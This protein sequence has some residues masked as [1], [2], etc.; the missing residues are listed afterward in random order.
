MQHSTADFKDASNGLFALTGSGAAGMVRVPG[1]ESSLIQKL[2]D[3]GADG[4]MCP[5]INTAEDAA[6]FVDAC[7]YPPMGMRSIG[8]FRPAEGREAYFET[9]NETIVTLAQIETAEAMGNLEGIAN[10]PGLDVLY[11]GPSDMSISYGGPPY[12]N[13]HDPATAERLMRIV[14]AAHAADKRAGMLAFSDEDIAL[15][16]Q[17]GIDYISVGAEGIIIKAGAQAALNRGLAATSQSILD[18]S[19]SGA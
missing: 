2:L 1:N 12:A 10:T 16:V 5:M 4:I 14:D 3:S 17:W 8:A 18:G 15:A 13:Y 7:R 6:A 19:A 11:S 9:A